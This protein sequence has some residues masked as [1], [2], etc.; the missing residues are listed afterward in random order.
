MRRE[1]QMTEPVT[2]NITVVFTES[3]GKTRADAVLAGAPDEARGWGRA[4]RN[5]I[6]P[7]RPAVGEEVAAARALSDLA[8]HLLERAAQRIEEWEGH[9]VDLHR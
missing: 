9:R 6:D 1:D 4:R 5:P 8:H 3:E 2:W 7:D